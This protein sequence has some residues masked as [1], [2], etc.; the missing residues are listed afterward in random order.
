MGIGP[1]PSIPIPTPIHLPQRPCSG[2][3]RIRNS[4]AKRSFIQSH[5]LDGDESVSQFVIGE[6]KR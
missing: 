6:E 4:Y 2:F 3:R 5:S 1:N